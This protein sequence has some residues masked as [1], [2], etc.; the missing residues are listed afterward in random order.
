MVGVQGFVCGIFIAVVVSLARP[1]I[2]RP[3]PSIVFIAPQRVSIDT[4]DALEDALGAQVALLGARL[5]FRTADD[6][7]AGLEPVLTRAKALAHEHAALGVMWLDAQPSGRWF[8]YILDSESEQIVVRPLSAESS[9]D[10]TI[11]AVALIARS[12]TEALMRRAELEDVPPPAAAPEPPPGDGLRL[13]VGYAGFTLSPKFPWLSGLA[14]GAAWIWRSG[15]YAG[16]GYVWYPAALVDVQAV[17]FTVTPYPITARGGYR[18]KVLENLAVS[19]E[20]S[21]GIELR[22]RETLRSIPELTDTGDSTKPVYFFG[23]SAG[24]DV[25]LTDW[26]SLTARIGPEFV[27]GT[28][29]YV[30][31]SRIPMSTPVYLLMGP[32]PQRFTA[33]FGLAI[34]R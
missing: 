15:P 8:L 23:L 2:A 28:R 11:E 3:E 14:V 30:T 5:Y 26:L 20:L 7:P 31:V 34:I 1:A 24:A 29:D 9:L 19:A 6:T 12:A 4:Q 16:L 22:T 13:E 33:A 32:Y 18:F 17:A 10:A 25:R 21:A 27:F